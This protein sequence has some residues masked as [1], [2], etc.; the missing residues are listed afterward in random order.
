M[1]ATVAASAEG[2]TE[3][4]QKGGVTVD[5]LAPE[6]LP[7]PEDASLAVRVVNGQLV[8]SITPLTG[9]TGAGKA[10]GK[11]AAQAKKEG[12]SEGPAPVWPHEREFAV[13]LPPGVSGGQPFLTKLSRKLGL[14]SAVCKFSGS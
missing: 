4:Q 11:A 9:T 12:K 3:Q 13:Q 6:P 1:V 14:I 2:K 10:K 8:V 5:I 7:S